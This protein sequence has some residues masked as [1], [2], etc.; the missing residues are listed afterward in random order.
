[1][2]RSER[3]ELRHFDAERS[4][5]FGEADRDGIVGE[6]AAIWE[7]REALAAAASSN[8][9]VLILG[10][11]GTGRELAAR[12]IHRNSA[13]GER[14][15]VRGTPARPGL[16]E[17]AAGGTLFF[18][19]ELP[20]ELE[21]PSRQDV[22]VIASTERDLTELGYDLLQRFPMNVQV[23]SLRDRPEDVPL[24]VRHILRQAV[25]KGE[26]SVARFFSSGPNGPE[27]RLD[28][29]LILAL[30]AHPYT[31][32]VR[33]LEGMVWQAINESHRAYV[34]LSPALRDELAGARAEAEF[35]RRARLTAL[36]TPEEIT[37]CIERNKCH[38]G[39]AA[40]ELGLRSRYELTRLMRLHGIVIERRA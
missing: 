34:A 36:P 27:P 11:S 18:D 31:D 7:L 17:E 20:Q 13:R 37:A 40:D 35:D 29:D 26:G 22:R 25:A 28:P 23:P 19:G 1:V 16:F 5:E 2:Q 33:E 21:D 38:A 12:A 4:M 39:R 32:H 9:H 10:E 14:A 3:I 6:S 15:F 24:L 8:E 30:V